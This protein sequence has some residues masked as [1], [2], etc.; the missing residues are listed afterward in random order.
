[1]VFIYLA[2]PASYLFMFFSA[3]FAISAVNKKKE[4]SN[5]RVH[6]NKFAADERGLFF[7]F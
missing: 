6:K 7:F 3:P 2:Q 1:L 5:R 4:Y